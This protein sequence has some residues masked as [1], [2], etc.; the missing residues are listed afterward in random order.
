MS[1]IGTGYDLTSATFSPDGRLF[2]VEYAQKSVDSSGTA[3]GIR[4]K[5][6][7]ILIVEKP[8]ISILEV[9][10]NKTRIANVSSSIGVC[11]TGNYAD[12]R[13]LT[14]YAKDQATNH[15]FTYRQ[16]IDIDKCVHDTSM[17]VFQ[18]T[19][20]SNR[21]YGCSMM[22]ATYNEK[23][24]AKLFV[25]EPSALYF[26]YM[27][28]ALGK[29]RQAAKAEIEKLDLSTLTA[30]NAVRELA[31][32]L[33]SIRDEAKE[34]NYKLEMACV[35]K[36]TNGKFVRISDNEIAAAEE[37]AQRKLEEDDDDEMAG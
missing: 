19:M 33:V 10:A 36:H 6:A 4:C 7:V 24:G 30:D 2:Q 13:A 16:E 34:M 11:C 29:H 27:G 21:P 28:W 35:G 12:I 18:Y 23:D 31:R 1:S 5:D 22:F 8:I 9:E 20:G 3:V 14:A 15:A 37:W 26:E 32:I 25:L 17:E